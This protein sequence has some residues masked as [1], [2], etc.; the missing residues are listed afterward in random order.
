[1]VTPC[2]IAPRYYVNEYGFIVAVID[3][4]PYEDVKPPD[5]VE[6]EYLPRMKAVEKKPLVEKA[7]GLNNGDYQGLWNSRY[8]QNYHLDFD[9]RER[10]GEWYLDIGRSIFNSHASRRG[11]S[12]ETYWR[13]VL[14]PDE[15]GLVVV[16]Y[17]P[18]RLLQG[19]GDH[20]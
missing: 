1:M 17:Y 20:G 13:A 14:R 9:A 3:G 2:R 8:R 5:Y 16:P 6:E 7:E 12:E 18:Q 11:R 19:A 10:V 15:K 4:C